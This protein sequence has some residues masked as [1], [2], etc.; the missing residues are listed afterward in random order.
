MTGNSA[1]CGPF[2]VILKQSH[3]TY[4]KLRKIKLIEFL[5]L[6]V[7]AISYLILSR[8]MQVGD[9]DF[10]IGGPHAV[11]GVAKAA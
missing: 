6:M 4:A 1:G 8:H 5:H 2:P 3:D 7:N 9:E 11:L 10:A